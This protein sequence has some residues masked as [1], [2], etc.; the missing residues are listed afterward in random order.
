MTITP[1]S[2]LGYGSAV[3]TINCQAMKGSVGWECAAWALGSDLPDI[4]VDRLAIDLAA[5]IDAGL[6]GPDW[7]AF[8]YPNEY[9]LSRPFSRI[10]DPFHIG[11]RQS[12]S[13]TLVA[14]GS[15]EQ[16]IGWRHPEKPVD[17]PLCD[18][19]IAAIHDAGAH[20][21]AMAT[22]MQIDLALAYEDKGHHSMATIATDGALVLQAFARIEARRIG[23]AT[24][25]ASRPSLPRPSL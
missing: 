16:A 21:L 10:P 17:T 2:P 14:K 13:V 4:D 9:A 22:E 19:V 12:A 15:D 20:A 11:T 7:T 6:L 24:P 3:L 18:K 25:Q 5:R 23:D 8:A 1:P